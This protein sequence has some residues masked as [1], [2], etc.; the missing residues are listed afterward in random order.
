MNYFIKPIFLLFIFAISWNSNAGY[1]EKYFWE[2]VQALNEAHQAN[3]L[4]LTN[5]DPQCLNL[6]I[7]KR[8]A[9]VKNTTYPVNQLSKEWI[10]TLNGKLTEYCSN[11]LHKRSIIYILVT[12]Y[13]VSENTRSV[14][15]N[16]GNTA[17]TSASSSS[18]EDEVRDFARKVL[19]TSRLGSNGKKALLL[20]YVQY[21][22]KSG[23]KWSYTYAL[24]QNLNQRYQ[25]RFVEAL[26]LDKGII[27]NKVLWPLSNPYPH[28]DAFSDWV[29]NYNHFLEYDC[30]NKD[31]YYCIFD[32]PEVQNLGT[33]VVNRYSNEYLIRIAPTN[34]NYTSLLSKLSGNPATGYNNGN[35]KD[36][37]SLL[38]SSE[39]VNLNNI[40]N[41][42][43]LHVSV[44]T[45]SERSF[46]LTTLSSANTTARIQDQQ[47]NSVSSSTD[48]N[49]DS[50]TILAFHLMRENGT[51]N[52]IIKLTYYFKTQLSIDQAELILT[53]TIRPFLAGSITLD[54]CITS[55]VSIIGG[56]EQYYFIDGGFTFTE[57]AYRNQPVLAF[58]LGLVDGISHSIWGTARLLAYD[59][60]PYVLLA[61]SIR[62]IIDQDYRNSINTQ[63]ASLTN[64]PSA[65]PLLVDDARAYDASLEGGDSRDMYEFGKLSATSLELVTG[66]FFLEAQFERM[67]F[68]AMMVV[69]R[70]LAKVSGLFYKAIVR[71]GDVASYTQKLLVKLTY[72]NFITSKA[73][74]EAAVKYIVNNSKEFYVTNK[75]KYIIFRNIDNGDV[76]LLASRADNTNIDVL[77]F[78]QGKYIPEEGLDAYLD[79]VLRRGVSGAGKLLDI[80]ELKALTGVMPTGSKLTNLSFSKFI[81]G[82]DADFVTSLGSK[83]VEDLAKIKQG[84]DKGGDLTEGIVSE[85]L[86][87][88][89]YTVTKDLGKY[90]SNNGF[91][92]VAYKGTLDNPTEIMIIEGK[93]FKQGQILD[94]FDDIKAAQGYDEPSGLALNAAN[95]NTGLPTQMSKKWCFEHVADELENKGGQFLQLSQ[96]LKNE[97]IVQ[98]FVFAIDKSTGAGYFTK[99][100]DG[101]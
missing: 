38:N 63:L 43:E 95:P 70:S 15:D 17:G 66:G 20:N 58:V 42:E 34:S 46:Q 73:K 96:A 6:C 24:D 53:E 83:Y 22:Y 33:G 97:N 26:T 56:Y 94:E 47:Y 51:S 16:W 23:F 84:L 100:S 21:I 55:L 101:F 89:G 72:G 5:N 67:S 12:N 1:D 92:V 54:G 2:C 52:L 82:F 61:K 87:K 7:D 69:N 27:D 13:Y 14:A 65:W 78:Q 71:A 88:Q 93:Q 30:E 77:D 37:A 36:L 48:E 44:N 98:R 8:S 60:N 76:L 32:D 3:E 28:M 4:L 57:N 68:N 49:T 18:N 90:G 40:I 35:I 75:G 79:D 64:I 85:A 25:D 31:R 99:L 45:T 29:I 86:R 41:Q 81:K 50:R 91:D 9:V 59:L 19:Y 74:I 10:N 80:A 62:Y 39:A 11:T